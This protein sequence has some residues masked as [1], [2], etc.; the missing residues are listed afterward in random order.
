MKKLLAAA[1]ALTAMSLPASAIPLGNVG[2]FT[3]NAGFGTPNG[4]VTASPVGPNYVFLTTAGGAAL[5]GLGV[6][7]ETNGTEL[8]TDPFSVSAGETLEYYFN[9]VTSDGSGFPDYAYAFLIDVDT[10]DQTLFF[11]ARTT[12]T[13]DTVP[14][15]GLP[16]LDAAATLTPSTTEIIDGNG[17]GSALGSADGPEWIHLG[18]SS[19][20]CFDGVGEGCGYTDWIFASLEIPVDGTYQA[21][22]GVVNANDQDFD[23]GIALAGLTAGGTVIIPSNA[24]PLPGALPLMAA[25]LAGLG[26]LRARRRSA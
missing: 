26:W 24:I 8:T 14:G 20:G 15:F 13:G 21:V 12:P 18:G 1:A 22:F 11:T 4:V 10:Q 6:G 16:P 7:G 17:P 25:G 5:S 19:G 9:Y 2:D 23:S 3:G